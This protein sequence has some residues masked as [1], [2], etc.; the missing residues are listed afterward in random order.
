MALVKQVFQPRLHNLVGTSFVSGGTGILSAA[1]ISAAV[2]SHANM[3]AKNTTQAF[4]SGSN[5]SSSGSGIKNVY[6]GIKH[7]PKYP[8]GFTPE[9]GGLK[10]SKVTYKKALE[11]LRKIE[12]GEWKKVY[13]DG[14]DKYGNKVSI[15]YF[16]SKSGKV[17]DVKVKNK[18]SNNLNK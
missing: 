18:W 13:K 9:R 4:K 2:T 14:Y 17:F 5:Y 11:D 10:S 6:D 15:H 3:V 12:P 8:E 16:E 7:A 1:A